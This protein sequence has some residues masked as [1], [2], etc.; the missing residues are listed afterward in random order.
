MKDH[1]FKLNR[2][3]EYKTSLEG[4]LKK[5]YMTLKGKAEAEEEKLR[6]ETNYKD[7]FKRLKIYILKL[8]PLLMQN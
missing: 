8:Y 1:K 3:L 6:K 4:F 2:V 5:E 7:Y